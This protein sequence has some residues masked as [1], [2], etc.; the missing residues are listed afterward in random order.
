M[1]E[2]F[3]LPQEQVLK[4]LNGEGLGWVLPWGPSHP[5]IHALEEVGIRPIPAAWHS[6]HCRAPRPKRRRREGGEGAWPGR[7]AR[8]GG[9]PLLR[10]SVPGSRHLVVAASPSVL[11]TQGR[12]AI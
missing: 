3:S 5:L 2:Q 7:Q 12:P 6:L 1:A 10:L 8:G 4:E 11:G 9:F